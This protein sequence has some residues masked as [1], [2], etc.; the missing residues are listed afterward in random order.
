MTQVSVLPY[1]HS[2]GWPRHEKGGR[3]LN[4][5]LAEALTRNW[6]TDAHCVAY[7][8]P[9]GRRLVREAIDALDGVEIGIA[10]FDIDCQSVHG[11]GQPA[12]ASWREQFDD[13]LH[14]LSLV[15]PNP[16]AYH[17]R[18]GARIV[19]R[20]DE[21]EVLRSQADAPRWSQQHAV[22][23]AYLENR[24]GI[25][26]DPGC[27][28]WQRLYRLPHASREPGGRPE[29]WPVLGDATCIGTITIQASLEDVHLARSRSKAFRARRDLD[30][31]PCAGDGRGVF[32]HLLR[33]RGYL[34]RPLGDH[35]FTIRCPN[36]RAHSTGST[37]DTS[38]LL[39]PPARSSDLGAIH[40]FHGHCAGMS[41]GD[42]LA[43]FA[44]HEL[45]AARRANSGGQGVRQNAAR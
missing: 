16:F 17:T 1:P 12:P 7:L 11:T 39:W 5:E 10:A 6:S 33:A 43:L 40:C 32:Y 42:W 37:G 34:I 4:V 41:V 36:E 20:L 14:V 24:F 18:G 8:S 38:T 44:D 35:R 15:H 29:S 25:V 23:I 22:A 31:T 13:R 3:A 45:D 26:A 2:R 30:F 27:S 21:P 9:N 19:Y 28:D